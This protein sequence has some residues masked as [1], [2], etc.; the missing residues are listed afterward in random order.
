MEGLNDLLKTGN[1]RELELTFDNSDRE[2]VDRV[3]DR[4]LP[5]GFGIK[6]VHIGENGT[7]FLT[8]VRQD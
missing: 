3:G 6:T 1:V 8:V 5:E 7:V 2:G 4:N